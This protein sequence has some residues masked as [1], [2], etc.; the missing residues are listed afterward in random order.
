M[1]N[2]GRFKTQ[3]FEGQR[4]I[5]AAPSKSRICSFGAKCFFLQEHNKGVSLLHVSEDQIS[6]T[7]SYWDN[8][9]QKLDLHVKYNKEKKSFLSTEQFRQMHIRPFDG[10]TTIYSNI[11]IFFLIFYSFIYFK[12]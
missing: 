5:V 4:Y 7:V 1:D 11:Q 3:I 10:A 12:I 8:A 9:N 2:Y 6:Y